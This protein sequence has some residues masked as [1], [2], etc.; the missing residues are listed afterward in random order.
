MRTV[1][2]LAQ[3][4]GVADGGGLLMPV[5]SF[6]FFSSVS[7]RYRKAK[8]GP[9]DFFIY[10]SFY[11]LCYRSA[12]SAFGRFVSDFKVIQLLICYTSI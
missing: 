3:K 7:D 9:S 6:S 1:L 5:I 2:N 4:K 11:K 8:I 12:E 10:T